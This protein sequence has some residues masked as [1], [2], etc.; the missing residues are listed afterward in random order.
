MKVLVHWSLL[1]EGCM[2]KD[3]EG[4]T[5]ITLLSGARGLETAALVPPACC[6]A[7]GRAF[8]WTHRSLACAPDPL[9]FLRH[10]LNDP[11][12]G[13]LPN[14]RIYLHWHRAFSP[15]HPANGL[16]LSPSKLHSVLFPSGSESNWVYLCL[17]ILILRCQNSASSS[18]PL[19]N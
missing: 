9:V 11:L 10:V 7:Q 17:G 16:H 6:P 12:S 3:A 4:Q 8:H 14:C 19:L 1:P 2:R 5:V 13:L 15:Q 18:F